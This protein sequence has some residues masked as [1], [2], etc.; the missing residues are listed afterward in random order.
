[1]NQ[2]LLGYNVSHKERGSFRTN[3]KTAHRHTSEI[4]KVY[5]E[6]TAVKQ[7]SQQSQSHAFFSFPS[8]HE[9]YVY[10]IL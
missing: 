9:S 4:L 8:A 6:T 10:S 3:Y 2:N 5:F 1:M 7:I